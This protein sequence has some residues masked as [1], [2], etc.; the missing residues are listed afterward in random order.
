MLEYFAGESAIYLMVINAQETKLFKIDRTEKLDRDIE[1]MLKYF[2]S[3]QA[4]TNAPDTFFANSQQLFQ[5]LFPKGW[6][7]MVDEEE[8]ILVP[9]GQLKYLPFEAL[10]TGTAGQKYNLSTAPYLLRKHTITYAYSAALFLFEDQIDQG[11]KL[12]KV[13]PGF[14]NGERGQIPLANSLTEFSLPGGDQLSGPA[15]SLKNF[16]EEATNCKIIHLSTHA[17]AQPQSNSAQIEFADTTMYL[18]QIY[19]L[20]LK[21]DLVVLDACESGIGKMERGEGVISLGRA[22]RYAGAANIISSLWKV[23]EASTAQIFEDFYDQV[24]KGEKKA[25]ALRQAKLN[26]LNHAGSD[27]KKSPYYWSGFIY[28]GKNKSVDL[29]MESKFGKWTFGIAMLLIGLFFIQRFL[30][31]S[32]M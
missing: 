31:S 24:K 17:S 15:A 27:L 32:R 9:D 12:L 23:N 2:Q 4:I 30:L 1:Q 11:E 22:F 25:S 14:F 20:N 7:S 21:A 19:G 10:I 18:P 28:F 13:A 3:A 6:D 8:L 26:Y 16:I 29:K 5:Q